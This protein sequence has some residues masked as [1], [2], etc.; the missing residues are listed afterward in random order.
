MPWLRTIARR[1]MLLLAVGMWA[2]LLVGAAVFW[3]RSWRIADQMSFPM[4]RTA[5]VTVLSG[6]GLVAIEVSSK[7]ISGPEAHGWWS[8]ELEEWPSFNARV[9]GGPVTP[10]LSWFPEGLGKFRYKSWDLGS[11][12]WGSSVVF[13]Y[14]ALVAVWGA[15]V[16]LLF[17]PT[18]IRYLRRRRRSTAGVCPSCGYDLR[19]TPRRCPECGTSIPGKEEPEG[20]REMRT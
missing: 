1:K 15:A 17:V 3:V 10:I 2:A 12:F 7:D 11:Y 14:W 6:Y 16:M 18:A 19:T 4:G 9:P 8:N 13:P 20:D 5:E